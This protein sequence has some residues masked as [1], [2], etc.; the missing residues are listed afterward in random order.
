MLCRFKGV[1]KFFASEGHFPM[2]YSKDLGLLSPHNVVAL[3]DHL[4]DK[5][6]DVLSRT[7]SSVAHCPSLN[8]KRGALPGSTNC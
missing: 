6:T 7:G 2:A 8:E 5:D 3:M 4:S 1:S